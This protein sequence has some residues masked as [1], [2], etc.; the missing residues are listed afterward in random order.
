MTDQNPNKETPTIFDGPNKVKKRWAI[1]LLALVGILSSM[2]N[3]PSWVVSL[4]T[5]IAQAAQ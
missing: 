2:D 3:L 1:G 5:T 4:A